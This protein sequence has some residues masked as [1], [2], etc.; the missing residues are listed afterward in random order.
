MM[1]E[2]QLKAALVRALPEK[3]GMSHYGNA[4]WKADRWPDHWSIVTPHEWLAIVGMVEDGLT[5]D[6]W[7]EAQ[8]FIRTNICTSGNYSDN[9]RLVARAPW[10][11]RAQALAD[12]GAI[13]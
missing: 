11:V 2:T 1:A 13:A 9:N 12:I 3:L 7:D 8:A 5:N 10:P 4:A 6:Q